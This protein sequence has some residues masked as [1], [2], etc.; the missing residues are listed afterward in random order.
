MNVT[1][2]YPE[3]AEELCQTSAILYETERV[4]KVDIG[5]LVRFSRKQS[6]FLFFF[7]IPLWFMVDKYLTTKIRM[8]H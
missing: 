1:V 5:I 2:E 3:K 4:D 7:C 8:P 6:I